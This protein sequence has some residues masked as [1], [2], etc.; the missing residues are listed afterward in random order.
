[1]CFTFTLVSDHHNSFS[2]GHLLFGARS[3][4]RR[5]WRPRWRRRSGLMSFRSRAGACHRARRQHRAA[6]GAIAQFCQAPHLSPPTDNVERTRPDSSKSQIPGWGRGVSPDVHRAPQLA[7]CVGTGVGKA[8][9]RHL[10]VADTSEHPGCIRAASGLHSGCTT[11][12]S[13]WRGQVLDFGH[14]GRELGVVLPCPRL[15]SREAG[16]GTDVMNGGQPEHWCSA[17]APA[18][19]LPRIRTP[20]QEPPDN[21]CGPRP[22]QS[23]AIAWIME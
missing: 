18:S 7:G 5:R 16:M 10:R 19:K 2:R 20:Q 17:R 13:T 3:G 22:R 15:V 1:M 9:G 6:P 12:G 11:S 23:D 21:G 8:S 4:V 14:Y